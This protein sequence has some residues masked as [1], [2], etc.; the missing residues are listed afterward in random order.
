MPANN[1]LAQSTLEAFRKTS[2]ASDT[3]VQLEGVVKRFGG[4][5]AVNG[6][7]LEVPRGSMFGF[8][9]PNGS[10]KTTTIRMILRIYQPDQGRV[11]VLGQDHG[12]AADDRVGYLPEERGL[13]RRM[14]VRRVL[15][16]FASLKGMRN[17]NAIIDQQ[18]ERLGAKDWQKKRIEELSKGMAQKVQFIVATIAKPELVILD[19]PFS[20]LD[21]VNLELMRDVVME[22][23][24]QGTTVI[25]S[26]HDMAIAQGMCDRV[27][28]IY[29][30]N[31]VLDGTLTEIQQQ[32]GACQV[33]VAL[34]DGVGLPEHI[35]GTSG[36]STTG[37]FTIL[38]LNDESARTPV[39]QTLMQAGEVEHFEVVQ[40]TLHD[41]FVRIAK[42]NSQ[43]NETT[44]EEA[45][46]A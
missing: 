41:I 10:G 12:T 11:S 7:D 45:S 16:Y 26:T 34:A 20:G 27:F 4:K 25:F 38:D 3:V 36:R 31:K 44:I 15:Q 22:L 46:H 37:K 24:A 33:R 43:D 5:P 19:E 6:V 18:L 32:Y 30:G 9:G 13:Y 29:Q 14:T 1:L 35:P 23:R 2:M 40:P 8:I 28:M 21:P 42:P 39:L 17:A